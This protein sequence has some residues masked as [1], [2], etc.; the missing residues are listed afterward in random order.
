MCIFSQHNVAN[1]PPFSHMDMVCC[2]NLLIYLEPPLQNKLISVFHYSL[3]PGGFLVLGTSEGIGGNANLFATEDRANKIFTKKATARQ[4]VVTFAQNQRTNLGELTSVTLPPKQI[5]VS[6]TYLEAQKEFDRRLLTL[7]TPATVF[8]NSELEV[9]HSRGNVDHYLKLA[10][11]RASFNILKMAREGLLLELRHALNRAKKEKVPVRRRNVQIKDGGEGGQASSHVRQV[12]FEVSPIKIGSLG[13]QC[14]MI[15]FEDSAR[16]TAE[17][18]PSKRAGTPAKGQSEAAARR[19]HKL[20]QELTATREYLNSV[21]ENQEA[22]NEELQSANEEI[23]SSNEELQSTNEELETAKEELQS[24]N[25]ELTTVNDELRNR[26]ID[27]TQINND[28]M[29]FLSSTDIAMVMLAGDLSIRRFTPQAQ[30]ILGLIL[31]DVGRPI[32]SINSNVD[33]SDLQ[34][35]ASQVAASGLPAE[36][37]VRDRAGVHYQMRVLPY[38]TMENKIDGCVFTLV[39]VSA[40]RQAEKD[41]GQT[42]QKAATS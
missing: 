19:A 36:R 4:H 3:R 22:M 37:Q 39:D 33:I 1:D 7:Y 9:I 6:W 38:R 25:E 27:I 35:M 24:A 8:V 11:G 29:N 18:G 23:L 32:T 34:E 2:R 42:G 21:I 41:L 30:K 20:E 31:G 15:T 5:D 10:P 26:N 40:S 17:P 13:E 14:F 28:L 12:N 16:D